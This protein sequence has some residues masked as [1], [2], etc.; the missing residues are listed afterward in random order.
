MSYLE[1]NPL[2][3]S[4]IVAGGVSVIVAAITALITLW[5]TRMRIDAD[6]LSL[7]LRD[8]LAKRIDAYAKLWS[9]LQSNVSDRIIERKQPTVEWLKEFL[10]TLNACHAEIGVFLTQEVYAK[11]FE[12]RQAVIEI[13]T[14]SA[15]RP[16]SWN[17]MQR[18]EEIWSR[19]GLA[20]NLKNDMG[21]YLSGKRLLS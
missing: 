4:A 9:L 16:L 15:T 21:S 6:I 8:V 2:V 1:A 12:F 20:T 5:A 7:Q 18:L 3:A 17:D 14:A 13:G 11:F 10:E 19:D